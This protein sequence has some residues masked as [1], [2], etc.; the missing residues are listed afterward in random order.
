ME[1][2]LI[3]ASIPVTFTQATAVPSPTPDAAGTEAVAV[4]GDYAGKLK[5]CAETA[6]ADHGD[7]TG[8]VD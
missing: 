7:I 4:S 8:A 3:P 5:Q 1:R 6:A 2:Q